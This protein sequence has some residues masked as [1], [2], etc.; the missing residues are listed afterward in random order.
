MKAGTPIQTDLVLVGGGHTHAIVLR[1]IGMQ[2]L[3]PGV[4]VTLISNLVDTPY[5]GMLPCHIA[6]QYGFDES[7]ID[8]RPLTR[9]A[10][11][12]LWMDEMIGLD[13]NRQQVHCRRHPPV[14]YDV[15]SIDIGSTPAM[16]AVPGAQAYAVPAKPV[17]QLLNAWQAYLR[18]VE[19]TPQTPATIGIVGGGVGGVELAMTM[20]VRLWEIMQAHGQPRDN[21]RVHL[22]HR[23][24]HLA[25]GRNRR[26]QQQLERL[27][28]DRNI[29]A[30]L[31]ETVAA[32]EPIGKDQRQVQCESGLTVKCDRLFWVTQAAAPAW[33][34]T[35]G[36]ATDDRGFILVRPTLQTLSHD[37]IFAAGDIATMPAHPRP[38]AGV[39]AVRQGPPL[40]RN[41]RRYLSGQP[42]LPFRPQ[43]QFLN[44]IDTG[45]GTAIASRGPVS[46]Q[47]RLCRAWKHRIDRNFMALFNQFPPMPEQPTRWHLLQQALLPTPAPPR[48]LHHCAGCAAKVSSQTLRQTLQRLQSDF[49]DVA[50]W[51]EQ[52]R[53]IMGLNAPD[54]A[55]VIR[56]PPG[57][58]AVHTVDYFPALLDDPFLFGQIGVNHCLS[59]LFAM[60][61]IPHNVLALVTLP[62]ATETKQAETL[63]H[64]LSGVYQALAQSR[65]F[66][67]GGHTTEGP[68]LSLGFACNGWIKTDQI[69]RKNGLRPGQSLI[70]T[71]PLGT[72][73]LFAA[74]MHHA[75]KG[76]WIE[77]AV[78][79]MVQSNQ[80][81]V[82]CLRHYG[83][84]ACTDVTGF[85]LAGHLW[86]MVEAS[87]VAVELDLTA[88]PV[89]PGARETLTAGYFSSLHDRNQ[90]AALEH[91]P[92]IGGQ[93]A[94][95]A[96][97][98][99]PQ[100]A[101][102]LLAAIPQQHTSACLS[103][104]KTLG[105]PHSRC[106]GTVIT[107][108]PDIAPITI[109]KV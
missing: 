60:G 97:L 72:G 25:T 16:M 19:A 10:G 14:S 73:T 6:G 23:G 92:Q 90:A 95:Y 55:A 68:E 30:H 29:Q 13:V 69:L 11:C 33:L 44:I 83:V 86:E 98:F 96:L 84:S 94:E 57:K 46:V 67:V 49:P 99:D 104:L 3:P 103:E 45:T 65:T 48:P 40:Y 2:G 107:A 64:L 89:L 1:K 88:L 41:L 53:I 21:V 34:K 32:V 31:Q 76:R 54:D 9:F 39:F 78:A 5:S 4:R 101:G 7:H 56:M 61:A 87:Q 50:A 106:I 12:R 27:F 38:K 17:P 51:P 80:A 24:S 26:T 59:D 109:K 36:L 74:D 102:G 58:L 37:N 8:L 85:G 77:T 70:L 62:Y 20:Q 81:A 35:T 108:R 93:R 22:F 28:C 63:Y 42:P 79:S 100:T 71:Q 18:T 91:I 52:D 43:K 82:D 66:L 15:L 75:A 105:Y 47:S